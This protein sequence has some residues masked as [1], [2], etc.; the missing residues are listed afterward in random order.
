[1][2][3]LDEP[4]ARPGIEIEPVDALQNPPEPVKA[5]GPI[6]SGN[7]A[8][9]TD[10]EKPDEHAARVRETFDSLHATLGEK[11]DAEAR[12][13]VEKLRAAAALKDGAALRAQ[14]T[15]VRQRH[16]WL[17]RELV[18]HPRL[19]ALLDELALLGL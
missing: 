8:V 17:Y 15:D 12:E 3:G 19:S 1:M 16:G 5:G 10:P 4:V 9:M 14:L 11:L 18:A 7:L 6:R 13:S 2:A